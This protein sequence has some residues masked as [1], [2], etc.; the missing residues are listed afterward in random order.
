MGAGFAVLAQ[1]VFQSSASLI[2]DL[3]TCRAMTGE[4]ERLT[5]YDAKV[6][7]LLGAVEAGDLRLVDRAEVRRTRRQLFGLTLPDVDILRSDEKDREEEGTDLFETKVASSRQI[8]PANWRF[9]T[10]EGAVW[11]INNPPRRIAPI[12]PGDKL[13]FKKASLGYYFIRI[14][15][16]I[17]VKGR[18]VS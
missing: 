2:E 16:Q 3:R 11:E 13:V 18:R 10:A 15:G 8:G 6:G 14:N 4:T 17:G 9:T 5:C 1:P 12:M 7:M